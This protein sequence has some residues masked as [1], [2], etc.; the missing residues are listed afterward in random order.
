MQNLQPIIHNYPFNL[1]VY[2][3]RDQNDEACKRWSQSWEKAS[4]KEK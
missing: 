2:D 4:E 1:F 3:S